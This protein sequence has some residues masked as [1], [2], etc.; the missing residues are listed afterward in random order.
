MKLYYYPGACSLSDHIALRE[1]G[2]DFQIE[3]VDLQ[4]K[5]T[6]SGEDFRQIN[7]KGYVPALVLDSGDVISENVAI[8]DWVASMYPNLG[9]GG[10]LGRTRLL[11]ALAFISSE[12]HQGFES[13]WSHRDAEEVARAK[14][15][16]RPKFSFLLRSFKGK[17]LF[18]DNPTVADF[19]LFVM[20]L[21]AERYSLDVET[22]LV[23]YREML[24]GSPHVGAAMAAEGL[25]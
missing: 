12:L 5:I 11:E 19:Y 20:L 14:A 23:G 6:S 25:N 9:V 15:S 3:R 21:W 2:A 22:H 18:G 10:T 8:L 4:T 13:L 17:F 24:K 16:L 1:A 7:A